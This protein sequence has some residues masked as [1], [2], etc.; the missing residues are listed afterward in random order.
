MMT[1]LNVL[2]V[3]VSNLVKQ[4]KRKDF[5]VEDHKRPENN[6]PLYWLAPTID[7]GLKRVHLS[8]VSNFENK[9]GQE[10]NI[11]H[12]P[13]TSKFI[14]F[15]L[16]VLGVEPRSGKEPMLRVAKID[17]RYVVEQGQQGIR[18]AALLNRDYVLAKVV[19]YDYVTLKRRMRVFTHQD[20]SLVGVAGKEKGSYSYHGLCPTNVE[21]LI[22]R[23]RVP[24]EDLTVE[25][26]R[27]SAVG[28]G[29]GVAPGMQGRGRSRSNLILIKK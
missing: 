9:R 27:K 29:R 25:V 6:Y 22:S 16:S 8:S 28:M 24:C 10:S 12:F 1:K 13:K 18:L 20:G 7:R 15:V 11:Y 23:H 26:G 3:F 4:L 17:G 5:V 19:E 2:K 14:A 21:V